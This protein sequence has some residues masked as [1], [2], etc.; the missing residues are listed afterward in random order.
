[1]KK[2]EAVLLKSDSECREYLEAKRQKLKDDEF[3]KQG[4][5]LA[6]CLRTWFTEV[7]Q[8]SG[9]QPV[10]PPATGG[11]APAD[12][13]ASAG[14]AAGAAPASRCDE[15]DREGD[16]KVGK[17]SKLQC[18]LPNAEFNHH[19]DLRKGDYEEFKL[20][21]EGKWAKREIPKLVQQVL[22]RYTKDPV[23]KKKCDNI[24]AVF[25]AL[26]TLN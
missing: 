16:E 26:A 19:L 12:R 1:M 4:E 8:S 11:R 14:A 5:V 18:K 7:L 9:I 6:A 10:A 23:P 22:K 20:A 15:D 21:L 3:R 13:P 24:E 25:K 2:A 17:L